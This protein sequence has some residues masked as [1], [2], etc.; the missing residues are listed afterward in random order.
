MDETM[1]KGMIEAKSV[2]ALP[3]PGV[4]KQPHD[5]PGNLNCLDVVKR[6][7]DMVQFPRK[8]DQR[9]WEELLASKQ[10]E[11]MTKVLSLQT[12]Q[13]ARYTHTCAPRILHPTCPTLRLFPS[14]LVACMLACVSSC[15]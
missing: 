8:Q 4:G 5:L 11:A 9:M 12:S 3:W 1:R 7:G 15:A 6:L 14:C 2:E 10:A 13:P